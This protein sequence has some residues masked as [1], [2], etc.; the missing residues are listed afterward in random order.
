M[1]CLCFFSIKSVIVSTFLDTQTQKK[2]WL[3]Q[4]LKPL[5]GKIDK[6]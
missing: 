3:V 1:S 2:T 6:W 5:V 4:L